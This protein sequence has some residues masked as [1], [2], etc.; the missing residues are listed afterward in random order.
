MTDVLVE[1]RLGFEVL[2]LRGL[3][4]FK[5]GEE[6]L[7]NDFTSAVFSTIDAMVERTSRVW[8]E[9]LEF[10]VALFYSK[11][12]PRGIFSNLT[13]ASSHPPRWML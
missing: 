13:K 3:G 2:L 9:C 11:P 12:T 4:L 5:F 10:T 1:G 8:L 7:S 6:D